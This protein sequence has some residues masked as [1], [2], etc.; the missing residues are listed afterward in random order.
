MV[1]KV[2]EPRKTGR[3]KGTPKTGGRVAGTPNKSTAS[4]K[5]ALEQ[6]F[7]KMGGVDALT[8]WAGENPTEFYKLYAKLLPVHL[9][10]EIKVQGTL[11]E[12]L[13]RAIDAKAKE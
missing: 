1:S 4:V 10:G 13:Q 12:R 6:A 7:E 9:Q 8:D 3:P 11:A 2:D 5:A